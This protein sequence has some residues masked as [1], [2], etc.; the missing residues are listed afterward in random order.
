MGEAE[1]VNKRLNEEV[2]GI[3]TDLEVF[4]VKPT[5]EHISDEAVTVHRFAFHITAM[6]VGKI[7]CT[8]SHLKRNLIAIVVSQAVCIT[9]HH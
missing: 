9:Q 6:I 4:C 2:F 8:F 5:F 1:R 7:F 3:K